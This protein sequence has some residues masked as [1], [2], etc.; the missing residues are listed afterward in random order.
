[1]TGPEQMSSKSTGPRP[2]RIDGFA[3][4]AD[5]AVLGNGS[6]VALVALDGQIDWWPLPSIDSAP[7]FAALL[8]ARRGGHLNLCPAGSFEVARRYLPDSNVLET[9]FRTDTGTVTVTDALTVGRA[10]RLPWAE[11][12]R[13]IQG[14]EGEVAL[15]WEIVPGDRFGLSKPDIYTSGGPDAEKLVV[16]MGDLHLAVHTF[17]VGKPKIEKARI[18]GRFSV[19]AGKRAVLAITGSESEPLFYPSRAAFEARV[20]TTVA[21]WREWAKGIDYVGDWDQAVRRSAFA[22]KLLLYAPTGAIAA[23][24]TTSLPERIGGNKNWDY[25]FLWVRDAAF[26]LNALINLGLDEEVQA[27]I[28]FLLR[29]IRASEP[30]LHIFYALDGTVPASEREVRIP[31]YRG[32]KPVRTGNDADGQLQLGVYGDLFDTIW[33]Y[34]DDGHLLDDGTSALLADIADR[35]CKAWRRKDAGIWELHESQHYTISKMGCWVALD[36]AV[37]LNERGQLDSRHARRWARER[38]AVKAW[39][40][41]HCWSEAKSSYTFYAGTERLDAATLLAGRTGFDRGER[42]A[43]TI[44]AVRRELTTGALVYRYSG[45]E[46]EEGAFLACSFWL[47]SALANLGRLDEAHALMDDVVALGNDVG[48]FAEQL[49]PATGAMLGNYPQGLSHLALIDAALCI[50]FARETEN[51]RDGG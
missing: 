37:R 9:T 23:A 1:L 47:V 40:D 28:S 27:A 17:D 20:D 33:N 7:I 5:Y 21:E 13:C 51:K 12:V 31:G 46:A 4:I 25:R 24:A 39:I 41:E 49:D 22:L 34:V 6:T 11:M 8:D 26:T 30:D 10:G 2:R 42:L 44:A 18:T 50:K 32:S 48:L 29:T 38:D 19:P 3:P 35:C 15:R 43:G 14:V 16:D 36:R 45:A